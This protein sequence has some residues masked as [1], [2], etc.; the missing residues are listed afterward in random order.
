V[1]QARLAALALAIVAALHGA[2]TGRWIGSSAVL[3]AL[4]ISAIVGV[5]AG[6][7]KAAQRFATLGAAALGGVIGWV[8]TPASLPALAL[9]RGWSA[10]AI[11]AL[12]GAALRAW[13]RAPE[14]GF[15]ATFVMGLAALVACGEAPSGHVYGPLAGAYLLA[16]FAALRAHDDGRAELGA[17]PARAWAATFTMLAI[18]GGTAAALA[19]ALPPFASFCRDR[20]IMSLGDATT[21]L[22]DRMVL[23]SLEGMLQSDEIVLRVYGPHT[24]YL[25]GVVYDHYQ[26]GQWAASSTEGTHKEKARPLSSGGAVRVVIVGN[27][28]VERYPIPLGA[29]SIAVAEPGVVVD[30]FGTVRPERGAPTVVRFDLADG[31]ADFPPAPP[32]QDD[33]RMPVK[34]ARALAPLVR[35]WTSRADPPERRVQIIAE[36]L[37]TEYR[38][39]L[40][41]ARKPGDPLLDFLSVNRQGHCEYFASAMAMLS[42]AAGVPARVVAG[43]RVAERNEL[44]GYDVVRER[45]AHA[46]VEVYLEGKGWQT[47]DATPEDLLAQNQAH[48]TPWLAALWDVAGAWWSSARDRAEAPSLFQIIAAL[49]VVIVVGL[50]VRRLRQRRLRETSVADGFFRADAP[51]PALVRL[52]DALARRGQTRDPAEP[53]ERFARR[54]DDEGQRAPAAL[55]RRYAALRYGGVGDGDSLFADMDSCAGNL[56]GGR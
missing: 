47:I 24:D 32:S 12:G 48:S 51:P 40:G 9:G 33:L 15:F 22:G 54:L 39:S 11:A 42:R 21:G 52:L 8:E 23:G 4:G 10:A 13:V 37:R 35:S 28:R 45:N 25:R 44:G 6:F 41:F 18:A 1:R 53:I 26:V 31:G 30:R 43:Y 56:S 5:R 55:L 38:Y 3:L 16:S 36:H 27:A 50:V 7:G 17:L 2:V 20:L 14:G 29:R 46:W 19:V 49:L 34:M